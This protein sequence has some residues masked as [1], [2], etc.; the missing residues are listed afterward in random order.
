MRGRHGA[1]VNRSARLQAY[2]EAREFLAMDSSLDPALKI[3]L[4]RHL[5]HLA[6]N[7][8]ENDVAHEANL[9]R[10][11]YAALLQIRC[12]RP[13]GAAKLERDRRKELEAVHSVARPA[14]CRR[15][16]P[17]L[18][19]VGRGVDPEKA[20]L[21]TARPAGSPIAGPATTS[22]FWISCWHPARGPD[23]VWDADAISQS[24][25]ALASEDPPRRR[26]NV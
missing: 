18:Q 26:R 14:L 8:R 6:L 21:Q 4:E 3:E 13:R 25:A 23:V 10:E 22:V 20:G 7:P 1:A 17:Y 11:Q 5:D 19:L 12:N 16:G 9:A 15:P 24:V 2:S